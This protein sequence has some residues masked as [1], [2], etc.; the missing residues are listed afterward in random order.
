MPRVRLPNIGYSSIALSACYFLQNTCNFI[1]CQAVM[2]SITLA[3]TKNVCMHG[4]GGPVHDASLCE[5]SVGFC[6][7]L[8]D[9]TP[10]LLIAA[11][12]ICWEAE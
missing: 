1:I 2:E 5:D 9:S 12:S 10:S 3:T 4:P 11:I 7:D 8:E 6:G